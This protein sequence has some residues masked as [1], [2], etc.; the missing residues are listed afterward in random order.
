MKSVRPVFETWE[1]K[2]DDTPPGYWEIKCHLIFG[3]K[4]SEKCFQKERFIAGVHMME[5]PSTLNYA[6]IVPR[7]LV[8]IDFNIAVLNGLDILSCDILNALPKC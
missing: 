1:K 5:T 3:V 7:D 2:E 6:S 8:H 4:T